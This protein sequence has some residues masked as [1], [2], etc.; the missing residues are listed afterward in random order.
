MTSH[1]VFQSLTGIA[2]MVVACA[3]LLALR[4]GIERVRLRTF[5]RQVRTDW[6]QVIASLKL[7]VP[8]N[9]EFAVLEHQMWFSDDRNRQAAKAILTQNNF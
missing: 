6:D 4:Y 5:Q 1:A 8:P 2:T 3:A 9:A 7:R